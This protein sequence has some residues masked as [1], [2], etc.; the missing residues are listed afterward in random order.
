MACTH[1]L[2]FPL[3][4]FVFL[5]VFCVIFFGKCP[6]FAKQKKE[7]GGVSLVGFSRTR[8]PTIVQINSECKVFLPRLLI[9]HVGHG[10][11]VQLLSFVITMQ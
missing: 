6:Y 10:V 9:C 2:L 7:G 4:T 11:F 3:K 1:L 5:C 8:I